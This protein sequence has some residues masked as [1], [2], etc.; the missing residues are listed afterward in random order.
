[1][2]EQAVREHSQALCDALVAG[3]IGRATLDF[4]QELRR[5][6]GEVIALLPLPATAASIHSLEH[7]LAGY[8][9]V[10]RIVGETEEVMV[11]TRWKDREDRPTVVEASHLSRTLTPAEAAPETAEAGADAQSSGG[12]T[13]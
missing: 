13:G 9:V 12:P 10:L 2:D 3:D 1:M 11:Q 6:L 5:N 8:T 4:S 7:G